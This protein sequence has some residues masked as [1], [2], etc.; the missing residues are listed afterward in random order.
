M[1]DV[2]FVV[3]MVPVREETRKAAEA[4]ADGMVKAAM[5]A[6]CGKGVALRDCF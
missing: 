2:Y 3:I 4:S 5:A 1:R 6:V